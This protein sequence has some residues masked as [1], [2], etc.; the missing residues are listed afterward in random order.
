MRNGNL[1]S[2]PSIDE[3]KS[4]Y[5]TYEEWKLQFLKQFHKFNQSSYRTYEEWKL[6][7]CELRLKSAFRSYR[8]YEEWKLYF[9]A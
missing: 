9:T 1:C 2:L 5:R 7:F 3:R 6:D 8:T 4:S